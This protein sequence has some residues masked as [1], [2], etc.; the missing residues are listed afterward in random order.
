MPISDHKK[1]ARKGVASF[2]RCQG[3]RNAELVGGTGHTE[4]L[5]EE[6]QF[7]VTASKDGSYPSL[8]VYCVLGTVR[9]P[10]HTYPSDEEPEAQTGSLIGQWLMVREQWELSPGCPVLT[11]ALLT[12]ALHYL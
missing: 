4:S 9:G 8:S 1:S 7:I 6:N 11:A 12:T 2:S 3:E 10:F 5:E